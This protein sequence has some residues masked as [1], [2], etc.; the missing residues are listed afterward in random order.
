LHSQQSQSQSDPIVYDSQS[1]FQY[2]S[3]PFQKMYSSP[4][5]QKMN[6]PTLSLSAEKIP[7]QMETLQVPLPLSS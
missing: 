1:S 2:S 4:F 3:P 5:F 6:I 7:S